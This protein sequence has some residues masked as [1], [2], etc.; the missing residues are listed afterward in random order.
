MLFWS[1]T[2]RWEGKYKLALSALLETMAAFLF[3]SAES[4]AQSSFDIRCATKTEWC[5]KRVSVQ[6]ERSL[7]FRF[8]R[9]SILS[10]Y[11]YI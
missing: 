4:V 10:S 1:Q 3:F 9:F 2:R 5:F 8:V 6:M 11:V 7:D